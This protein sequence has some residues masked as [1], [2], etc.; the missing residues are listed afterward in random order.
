MCTLQVCQDPHPHYCL[1]I[2]AP[3]H[4][5]GLLLLWP[6]HPGVHVPR[7]ALVLHQEH[8]RWARVRWALSNSTVTVLQSS[9]SAQ[10]AGAK[11]PAIHLCSRISIMK[12]QWRKS[13]VF[14]LSRLPV[15][16][17]RSAIFIHT[18]FLQTCLSRDSPGWKARKSIS[19]VCC[20]EQRVYLKC[21]EKYLLQA[22]DNIQPL[23]LIFL[24]GSSS[25]VFTE[26][27]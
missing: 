7:R 19:S 10:V 12:R 1:G 13:V 24:S 21:T 16:P 20:F 11:T 15:D 2:R 26:S 3:T 18:L 22:K 9:C 6:S 27:A 14:V 25:F 17:T 23:P 5:L 8:Q 4:H